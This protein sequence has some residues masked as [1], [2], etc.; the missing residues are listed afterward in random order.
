MTPEQLQ[1]RF[2]TDLDTLHLFM[3]GLASDVV[4]T[5]NGPVPTLAKL[6][7]R[8]NTQ[9]LQLAA[10]D[11]ATAL[12]PGTFVAYARVVNAGVFNTVR[13]SLSSASTAG[14][15]TIDVKVNGVSVLTTLL[16]I[17]ANSKTSLNAT[18]PVVI[19]NGLVADDNEISIDIVDAGAGAKGL[20]VT[21]LT[22]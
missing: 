22:V 21:L 7:A 18:V 4:Q 10:S 2:G 1:T 8:S 5:D 13:A 19:G 14:P 12:I 3:T 16:T 6:A 15:V 11:M 9:F 20:I 17:D